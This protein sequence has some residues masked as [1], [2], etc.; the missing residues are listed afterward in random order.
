M[1]LPLLYGLGARDYLEL[2][3][4]LLLTCQKCTASGLFAVHNAKRKVTFYSLPTVSFREQWVVECRSCGQRFAVPPEMRPQFAER[5]LTEEEALV[6]FQRL[7]LGFGGGAGGGLGQNG[8]GLGL[9]AGNGRAVGPTLYQTLQVD[10]AADPDVIEAAFR[11]LALKFHPDRSTDP[12]APVRMRALLEAK[13]VLLDDGKRRAYDA[14]IGFV[15]PK[16]I[17]PRPARPPGMR[18]EDV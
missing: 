17:P 9:G 14:S 16:P 5:L 15:R 6:Q 12:D 1:V 11:R 3:G 8:R 2:Q 18:P 13:G 7:G 10:P 4:Y